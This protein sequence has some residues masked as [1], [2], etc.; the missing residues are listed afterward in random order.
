MNE[1]TAIDLAERWLR[2]YYL[3]DGAVHA[4]A[5]TGSHTWYVEL[6]CESLNELV[7][8]L[9]DTHGYVEPLGEG[10]PYLLHHDTTGETA[11]IEA[12]F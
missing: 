4:S 7:A 12:R 9:V 8:V 6:R 5:T 2:H 10:L 3:I 1:Q 11:E